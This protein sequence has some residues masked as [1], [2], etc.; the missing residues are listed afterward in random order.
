MRRRLG[1][2]AILGL[3]AGTS[4]AAAVQQM[5]PTT[6]FRLTNSVNMSRSRLTYIGG[7][8][9]TNTVVGDPRVSGATFRVKLTDGDEQ[10]VDLPAQYWFP[11]EGVGGVLG[12]HYINNSGPPGNPAVFAFIKREHAGPFNL[13]VKLVG[14][15]GPLDV[16]PQPTA[17]FA[18]IFQLGTGDEYC[19]GGKDVF[20]ERLTI[21]D[22][23]Y[24]ARHVPAPAAC[25]EIT[26][27]TT[28]TTTSTTAI[29]SPSTTTTTIATSPSGALLGVR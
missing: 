2:W 12:F 24:N 23:I 28:S 15:R 26:C 19:S 17:Q 4:R 5:E 8:N 20:P 27:P 16:V 6:E 7:K 29:S 1:T 13:R 9:N 18:T 25:A 10:C 22:K 3:L 21:T 14:R 11:A